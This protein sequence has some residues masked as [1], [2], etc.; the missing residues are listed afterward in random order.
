MEH[1]L[2]CY[3]LFMWNLNFYLMSCILSSNFSFD[4]HK[5]PRS[6]TFLAL[7]GEDDSSLPC[8]KT[9]LE[10]VYFEFWFINWCLQKGQEVGHFYLKQAS[11]AYIGKPAHIRDLCQKASPRAFARLGPLF[12]SLLSSSW[13]CNDWDPYWSL[14]I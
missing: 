8:Q 3:S 9:T 4:Q 2:K 11:T 5:Q 13:H 7:R 10:G 12:P 6:V 14:F 1:R